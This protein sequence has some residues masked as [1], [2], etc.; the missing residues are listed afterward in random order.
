MRL[1]LI[2]APAVTDFEDPYGAD[3]DAVR[4]IAEHPPLGLLSLAA[5]L[6]TNGIVPSIVD[7]NR[8]YN[9]YLRSP[10]CG[11]PLDF[12]TFLLEHFASL[13]FDV[14][15]FS[16]MCSSY[17]LTLRLATG[18]KA[19]HPHATI[20]LGGPQASVVDVHTLASFPAVDFIVRGEAEDTL[21]RLIHTI[22]G[23]EPLDAIP[24]VTY[25]QGRDIVRKPDA[26]LIVDLDRLPVPAFHLYPHL[27]TCQYMPIEL[28]RG[29][30][31][32]CTFCSTNDFFRRRFRLKSPQRVLSEMATIKATHG[33]TTFD[34]IHDMFTVNREMVVAFCEALLESGQQFYWSC[35][36]RTDCVDEELL[37]IMAEAG[38]QGIYFGIETGSPRMQQIVNKKLELAKAVRMIQ[39]ADEHRMLTGVSVITG[40]PEETKR[41]LAES[42]DFLMNAA[43]CNHARVQLHLLAPLAETPIEIAHREKLTLDDIYSDMSAQSWRQDPAD[44]QLIKDHPRIFPNFYAIP[45]PCLDRA[46]LKELRDFVLSGLRWFR[47]LMIGLHQESGSLINVFELWRPWRQER[48]GKGKRDS[49]LGSYYSTRVFREDFLEFLTSRYLPAH[50][51]GMVAVPALVAFAAVFNT[52]SEECAEREEPSSSEA[53]GSD[54]LTGASVPRLAR[55][56]RLVHLD[57]DY[58]SI[59]EKLRVRGSLEGIPRRPTILVTRQVAGRAPEVVRL[60]ERSARL[61]SLCDGA[62]SVAQIA[63]RFAAI[64]E[65]REGMPPGNACI[66]GLEWLRQRGL[67]VVDGGRTPGQEVSGELVDVNRK[68][69][70]HVALEH[71]VGA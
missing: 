38:C 5:A 4:L 23:A 41:D 11:P 36:A 44:R 42:I 16:T 55:G 62:A 10:T 69:S 18:I 26:P 49:T 17:P 52:P 6:E 56:I 53:G 13:P 63:D 40:F 30:P 43:R 54:R 59:R 45:T 57:A 8:L 31:F 15:G 2:G 35:S 64:G 70:K 24:G 48:R 46:Y 14:Y 1:C 21:P 60:N 51:R 12:L 9:Q 33:I 29:C 27:E 32:A 7:I 28:G 50:G 71:P 61:L 3:A 37:S 39:C 67:I 66:S 34:L 68:Q 22:S 20:I 58:R 65:P 19:I 25:R 47:W